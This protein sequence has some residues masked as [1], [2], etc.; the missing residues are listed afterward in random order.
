VD[1]SNSHDDHSHN[2]REDEPWQYSDGAVFLLRELAINNPVAIKPLLQ[3][4]ANVALAPPTFAHHHNLQETIWRQ[5]PHILKVLFF[6][7]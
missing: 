6:F 3:Y 1:P 4:L 7:F 2:H 5:L